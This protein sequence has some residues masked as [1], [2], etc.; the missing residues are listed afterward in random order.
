MKK[1]LLFLTI[2]LISSCMQNGTEGEVKIGNQIW[3]TKNLDVDKFNNGDKIPEA[4]T[5]EEWNLAS[6][7]K[8]PAWCY[9]NNDFKNGEKYGKLYNFYA[10]KD[11]RGLVPKGWHI[12]SM[13]EWIF[14]V[15]YLGG[16]KIAGNKLKSGSGWDDSGNGNNESKFNG[17][18]GGFRF[19]KG[20]F[21]SFLGAFWSI[22]ESPNSNIEVLVIDD[23]TSPTSFTPFD[24]GFGMSVR[25]IKN[26]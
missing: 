13:E 17:L 8:T 4:K 14:L 12:P 25:L 2:V 15:N 16:S 3:T 6:K 21:Y 1:I 7:N 9:Y 26:D 24:K 18:P 11:P 20:E 19:D 5:N 22:T 23:G 10:I